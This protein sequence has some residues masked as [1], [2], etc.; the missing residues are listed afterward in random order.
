MCIITQKL[1]SYS[2]YKKKSDCPKISSVLASWKI[3][4]EQRNKLSR[5]LN[6]KKK[7]IGQLEC[8][9]TKSS[10][11]ISRS[12]GWCK[13]A[14]TELG[15]EHKTDYQLAKALSELLKDKYVGSFGDRPGRYKQ[16]FLASGN[17]K[18]YD[19]YDGAPFV[20]LRAKV[21]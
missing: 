17:V 2:I 7:K 10:Q 11:P 6:I 5:L 3:L 1:H 16:L 18:G 20:R 21:L 4:K 14:S 15:G 9:S 19:A 8:E 12:G 13:V